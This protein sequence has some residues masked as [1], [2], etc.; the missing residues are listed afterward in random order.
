AG[1]PYEVAESNPKGAR[2]LDRHR[3]VVIRGGVILAVQTNRTAHRRDISSQWRVDRCLI[4]RRGHR[5]FR[6]EVAMV[7]RCDVTTGLQTHR[8]DEGNVI[9]RDRGGGERAR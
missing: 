1:K 5:T 4:W 9:E 7:D 3:I 8:L 2:G 6:I